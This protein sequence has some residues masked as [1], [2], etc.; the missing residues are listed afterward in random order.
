MPHS[1]WAKLVILASLCVVV[2]F[3]NRGGGD[4]LGMVEFITNVGGKQAAAGL[5]RTTCMARRNEALKEKRSQAFL[6]APAYKREITE[7]G[8]K[9]LI[10]YMQAN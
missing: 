9:G 6:C 2:Y 7:L 10:N 8:N 1:V 4:P 5:Y 3:G